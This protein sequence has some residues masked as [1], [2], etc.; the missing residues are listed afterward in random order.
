EEAVARAAV[1]D[2]VLAELDMAG[3][4]RVEAVNKCDL[5]GGRYRGDGEEI[6]ISALT[7]E[8]LTALLK[9]LDRILS[10]EFRKATLL[11]PMGRGEVLS[12][13]YRVG[14]V[15]SVR[16][17][18]KGIRVELRLHEKHYGR[19]REFAARGARRGRGVSSGNPRRDDVT[20]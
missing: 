17:L 19:Y 14:R 7:G 16:Y 1:V 6:R 5:P 13:L 2:R 10:A 9:R 12:E 4:P 15:D 8:G 3:T 11:I 18:A 20:E